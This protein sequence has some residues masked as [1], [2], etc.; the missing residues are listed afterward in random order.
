MDISF[1]Q[2]NTSSYRTTNPPVSESSSL[3]VIKQSFPFGAPRFLFQVQ[4]SR[5]ADERRAE[6]PLTG[7][8]FDEIVA[9][10]ERLQLKELLIER[11]NRPTAPAPVPQQ[12]GGSSQTA[13]SFTANGVT[14][15]A[16]DP[17]QETAEL[18]R[19]L[20]V[21]RNA[22]VREDPSM[23]RAP[24]PNVIGFA[25]APGSAPAPALQLDRVLAEGEWFCPNCGV[26]NN[27]AFCTEC[28]TQR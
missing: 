18:T 20:Q 25:P 13:L 26:R 16:G 7:A 11:L 21:L 22:F 8:Q 15:T 9:L 4:E 24:D 27:G 12:C 3:T 1:L 5:N 6:Y 28:G 23:Q 2:I 14:V 19:H 10:F 17:P